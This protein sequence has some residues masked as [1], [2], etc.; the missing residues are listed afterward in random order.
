MR[1]IL[2]EEKAESARDGH[3]SNGSDCNDSDYL[4]VARHGIALFFDLL[5]Y[6]PSSYGKSSNNL[7]LD[8]VHVRRVALNAGLHEILTVS[9]TKFP[10]DMQ[11]MM[12]GQQM[13]IATGYNGEIPP[14]QGEIVRKWN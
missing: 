13:L 10:R 8:F 14:F 5:R 1:N 7:K 11:V 9:M 2:E 4:E 12:M 3:G 6:D